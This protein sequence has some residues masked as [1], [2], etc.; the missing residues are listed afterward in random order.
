MS[1]FRDNT[2]SYLECEKKWV[3]AVLMIVGGFYG[4]YTYVC[5]GGV[6]CNAQTGNV[7]LLAIKLGQGQWGKALYYLVPISAYLMGAVVSEV[8][9]PPLK[10]RFRI[11]WETVLVLF[12]IVVVIIMGFIPQSAPV[13][14]C[15][16]LVNFIGSMQYNTFRQAQGVPMATTFCT[17]HIRN[18]G[19]AL[20]NTAKNKEGYR[21]RVG[22]HLLMLG[23][24]CLG[25]VVAT[26]F[27]GKIEDRAIWFALIP[28]IVVFV[29]LL[30]AD[31]R[32]DDKEMAKVPNGH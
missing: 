21:Q 23:C 24:F 27:C 8:V 19:I 1:N 11:R 3:Y 16:V 10:R 15:Q 9:P 32:A 28:L 14:I 29:D 7:L 31:L 2:D 22:A 6:F 5:K 20:V 25:A 13:Q 18:L 17:N 26:V 12:E 30:L 4:A